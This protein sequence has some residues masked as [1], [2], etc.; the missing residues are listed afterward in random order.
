MTGQARRPGGLSAGL[1]LA[2]A[3]SLA[4]QRAR[5]EAAPFVRGVALGL[6][7]AGDDASYAPYL[8]EIAS[9]GA[10]SVSLVYEW[11]VADVRANEIRR[12]T[13]TPGDAQLRRAIADAHAL[14]LEV[15]L[16]PIVMLVERDAGAW[17]GVLAPTDVDAWFDSYTAFVVE[18]AR[19]AEE[20][21]VEVLSVGSELGSM[22]RYAAWN[23]V[24]AAARSV[25]SGK[26]I[27][28]ANWDNYF[29]TPFWSRLDLVGVTGYFE[30]SP[31]ADARPDVDA[32][33]AAWQP[34]EEALR[35]FSESVGRPVV[36]TEIGY[37]SQPSAAWRPWD[38]TAAS[39]PD[40]EAQL[41]AYRALEQALDGE[42]WLGGLFIW[43][44]FGDGGASCNGYTPR[45]KPAELVVRR[46]FGR[47]NPSR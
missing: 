9:A 41:T 38:Y 6:H 15:M 30:L 8:W 45:H 16:F 2:I 5:A 22:E 25:Y 36:I 7:F 39:A 10:T 37:V 40:I 42:P 43:N 17:R 24:I 46:W 23:E 29:N 44:W 14:G 21:G 12:G 13:G 31:S 1:V 18:N 20:T 19:L 3:L 4:P 26:L 32:L 11:E 27:Y 35:V 34:F 33:V 28:S 47:T